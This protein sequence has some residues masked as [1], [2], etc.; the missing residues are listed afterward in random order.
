MTKEEFYAYLDREF[1]KVSLEESFF[2]L[3]KMED[4]WVRDYAI[5]RFRNHQFCPHCRK[6]SLKKEFQYIVETE[7][8]EEDQKQY[9]VEVAYSICPKCHEREEEAI[10]S[11]I[12]M[13]SFN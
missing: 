9:L 12:D 13:S 1:E 10:V 2:T 8:R 11:R 5:E 3:I 4:G 7:E 6:Y